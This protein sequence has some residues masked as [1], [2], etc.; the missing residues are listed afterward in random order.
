MDGGIGAGEL[1]ARWAAAGGYLK[2]ARAL[3]R[4]WGDTDLEI[5]A[6]RIRECVERALGRSAEPV[7]AS[8]A[9]FGKYVRTATRREAKRFRSKRR[10]DGLLPEDQIAD[11]GSG[12]GTREF[13]R[14]ME[15]SEIVQPCLDGLD[16]GERRVIELHYFSGREFAEIGT[17]MGIN[18][19]SA[20]KRAERGRDKLRDCLQAG[21]MD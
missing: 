1:L 2:L 4:N 8:E 16:E 13:E 19:A 15:W 10:P 3:I 7:F 17:T 21:E 6:D 9:A 20:R 5:L 14:K 12:D 18:A 11:P